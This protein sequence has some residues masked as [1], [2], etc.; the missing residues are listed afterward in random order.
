MTV[1]A[2]EVISAQK[3]PDADALR[4]YKIKAP[5]TEEIQIIANLDRIYQ[6]GDIVAIA[7]VGSIL[8]DSTK[9]KPTKLRGLYSYGM[10]LGKV[11]VE[12]G[13]DLSDIYCQKEI[14]II[15]IHKSKVAPHASH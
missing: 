4:L 7:L 9:I 3:H 14:A 10:A 8:K 5:Q 13:E 15:A 11:D 12:V 2:M 6:R 1:M